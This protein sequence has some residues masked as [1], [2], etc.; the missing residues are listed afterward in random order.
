M[1]IISQCY[2]HRASG[3]TQHVTSCAAA[4]AAAYL[5]ESARPR[6]LAR[7]VLFIS[8]RR[9]FRKY[10]REQASERVCINNTSVENL[11]LSLSLFLLES[12]S[13]LNTYTYNIRSVHLRAAGV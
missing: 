13:V 10:T 4:A 6:S 5:S 2:I 1:A 3:R 8:A 12:C 7:V 11:S 9:G